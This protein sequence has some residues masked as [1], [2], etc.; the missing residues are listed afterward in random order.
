MAS[1][2]QELFRAILQVANIPNKYAQNS[3]RVELSWDISARQLTGTFKI[4][5]QTDI[6]PNTGK[7]IVTALDFIESEQT[8]SPQ[9]I[10]TATLP[11]IDE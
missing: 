3:A 4:P 2:S 8:T 11:G 1:P 10:E 9:G 6:N 7:Y 5:L